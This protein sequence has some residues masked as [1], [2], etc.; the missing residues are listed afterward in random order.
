LASH[1][2]GAICGNFVCGDGT[3]VSTP[4]FV[5]DKA[6]VVLK[7]GAYKITA[8][9]IVSVVVNKARLTVAAHSFSTQ[10]TTVVVTAKARMTLRAGAVGVGVPIR[11][12]VGKAKL[13]LTSKT[14]GF[15][16]NQTLSFNKASL[17]L[18][19][20]EIHKVGRAGLVPT[21]CRDVTL[22]PTTYVT[23]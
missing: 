18:A 8:G 7:G 5:A 10:S 12:Q 19:G 20:G 22:V 16:L 3:V 2:A 13:T 14:Y 23:V 9:A 4:S 15:R 21:V 6:S 1:L 17:V 11:V